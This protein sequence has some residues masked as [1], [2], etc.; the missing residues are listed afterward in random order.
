ME[1]DVQ[2]I[3][4]VL[5]VW[6]PVLSHVFRCQVRGVERL[7]NGP[8]LLVANHNVGAPLE[9]MALLGAWEQRFHGK[10]AI[11]GMAHRFPFRIP[12]V[13]QAFMKLGAIPATYEDA[14]RVLDSGASL[15]VFP[16]G[17]YESV[18]PFSQRND[19]DFGGR[20]GWAKIALARKLP[21]VPISIVGT[22][23]V[24][25]VFLRSRALATVLIIPRLLGIR[26]FPISLA[27]LIYTS[28]A[29][30]VLVW[31]GSPLWLAVVAGFLVFL[32]AVQW[33]IYPSRITILA[34]EPMDISE[35]M[36]SVADEQQRLDY[37]Y[38]EVSRRIQAGMNQ[39]VA[40]QRHG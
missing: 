1:R 35:W 9:V 40:D 38:Q 14:S 17:N 18:R 28:A 29:S 12:G 39:L 4:G 36:P 30:L 27:Q 7:G 16:G 25:P 13:A 23:S 6:N 20:K 11:Y 32:S 5:K 22:H 31:V 37:L 21:I 15:A 33:P 34:A 2:Y 10:K 3:R 19:C 26:W 24:N 8:Y